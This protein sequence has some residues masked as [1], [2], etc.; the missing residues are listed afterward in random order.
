MQK[1]PCIYADYQAT[2]PVD[3]RVLT[4]MGPYWN[5]SFGNPHSTDHI[6]GWRAEEATRKA[7]SAVAGL[8]GVDADEV[9]FT[10]GATEANNLALLGLARHSF[11][12]AKA[13]F[14]QRHR[15]QVRARSRS[16]AF[17]AGGLLD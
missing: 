15:T 10:S 16:V 6:V 5:K 13:Y 8:I 12:S 1:E 11:Q 2:T 4:A 7:A 9:I 17:G 14:G 3:S